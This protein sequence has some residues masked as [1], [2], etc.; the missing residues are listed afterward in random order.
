MRLSVSLRYPHSA[1]LLLMVSQMWLL[2]SWLIS[3]PG[4]ELDGKSGA[5]LKYWGFGLLDGLSSCK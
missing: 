1:V 5:T 2:Q 3:Q 4:V